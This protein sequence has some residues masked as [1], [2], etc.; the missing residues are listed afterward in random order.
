MRSG[1]KA[2]V[3]RTISQP[4]YISRRNQSFS[5]TNIPDAS[6]LLVLLT[7][8]SS[9]GQDLVIG[10]SRRRFLDD[11]LLEFPSLISTKANLHDGEHI[12][13]ARSVFYSIE[14]H[15]GFAVAWKQDNVSHGLTVGS[16]T[17]LEA[18]RI[19]VLAVPHEPLAQFRDVWPKIEVI[20]MGSD[21]DE[22]RPQ[23]RVWR[24]SCYTATKS[25]SVSHSRNIAQ[26]VRSFLHLLEGLKKRHMASFTL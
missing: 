3:D 22:A 6:G 4:L 14:A 17:A 23:A 5:E 2:T 16:L 8:A 11:P 7:G 20:Q 25:P 21:L 9:D 13:V 15:K 1:F 24:S 26:A 18:G 12:R 19:V 10:A